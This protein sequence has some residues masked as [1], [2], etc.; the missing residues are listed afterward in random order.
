MTLQFILSQNQ[1]TVW[2]NYIS[3]N[4]ANNSVTQL[5]RE[6]RTARDGDNGAYTIE[7]AEDM[8]IILAAGVKEFGLGINRDG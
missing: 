1:I 4:D 2:T 7:T 3:V 8:E 5:V 6:L